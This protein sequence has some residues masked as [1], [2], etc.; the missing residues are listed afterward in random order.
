[1]SPDSPYWEVA[2]LLR[3]QQILL[4]SFTAVIGR[5]ARF[6]AV[7]E[8]KLLPQKPIAK[9]FRMSISRNSLQCVAACIT[10][11]I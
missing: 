6:A 11:N 2:G 7:L 9:P 5:L 8:E 10:M 3:L 4:T 1:M